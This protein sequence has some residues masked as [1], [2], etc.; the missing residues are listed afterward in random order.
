MSLATRLVLVLGALAFAAIEANAQS[1]LP[2][3]PSDQNAYWHDCF[4]AYTFASGAKYVGEWRD[5]KQHGQGTFT[6]PDGEKYVGE[7]RD[8]KQH[9]QGTYT[10]P[11]GA[12]YVGEWRDD[13][14][15]G[16]GT[17]TFPDGEKY[18][19]DWRDDKRHG[20]GTVIESNGTILQQGYYQ[21]DD[22]IGAN[23]PPWYVP[24]KQ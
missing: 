14:Q 3:C 7:W 19:G 5:D 10:F 11:S 15:H 13:K 21:N 9:G 22:F 1:R 24:P 18:V 23:R 4:G 17:F 8:N 20:Y 2:P 16:Q 6:F 12:K